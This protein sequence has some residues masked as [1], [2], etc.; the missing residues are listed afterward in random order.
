MNI[1]VLRSNRRDGIIISRANS[2][3]VRLSGMGGSDADDSGNQTLDCM[4][5]HRFREGNLES[6]GERLLNRFVN[7]F[8]AELSSHEKYPHP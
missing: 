2:F 4:I 8:K 3:R 6:L 7:A 5:A 1:A